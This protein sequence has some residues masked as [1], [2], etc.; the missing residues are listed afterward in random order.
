[1]AK[2]FEPVNCLRGAPM[3]RAERR[4]A[5]TK[6]HSVRVFRVHLDS[7]GYDDGGA[8]WGLESRGALLY[9]ATDGENYR[10]FCRAESRLTALREFRLARYLLKAGV[11]EM[12]RLRELEARGVLGAGGVILR[13]QMEQLGY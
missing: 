2:Q 4:E 1:M 13:Q 12:S 9:C 8:Y 11:P 5:P 7:G 10:M 3:G 6:P